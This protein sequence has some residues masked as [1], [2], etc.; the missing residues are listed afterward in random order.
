MTSM[1]TFTPGAIEIV[2]HGCG[3][4][5]FSWDN[6]NE[7]G[8]SVGL[9]DGGTTVIVWVK[10]AGVSDFPHGEGP[11]ALVYDYMQALGQA[12]YEVSVRRDEVVVA[13]VKG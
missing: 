12:G 3:F 9:A 13:G 8:Y 1:I 10:G 6:I 5:K 11:K 4:T 7:P 2:L